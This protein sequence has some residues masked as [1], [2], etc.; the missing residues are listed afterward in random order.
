APLEEG[1][2]LLQTIAGRFVLLACGWPVELPGLRCLTLPADS[3][4]A[5]RYGL[6]PG[7]VVLLRPDAIVAARWH[8]FDAAAVQ[9]ALDRALGRPQ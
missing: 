6:A 8:R 4:A 3:L 9:A 7:S 1:R 5:Q 2:W